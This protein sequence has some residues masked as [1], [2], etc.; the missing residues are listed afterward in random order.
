MFTA[1]GITAAITTLVAVLSMFDS[2]FVSIDRIDSELTA[3]SPDRLQVTLDRFYPTT[4]VG[5]QSTAL[6]GLVSD[7]QPGLRVGSSLRAKAR[8]RRLRG[9]ARHGHAMWTP[10]VIS[11]PPTR[12]PGK[13]SCSPGRRRPTWAS[14]VG[15]TIVLN[16]PVRQGTTFV[17]V[18][19]DVVVSGI[20][21]NPL[22]FLAYMDSGDAGLFGMDGLAN[23]VTV[24]PAAGASQDDVKRALL[25]AAGGGH[26]RDGRRHRTAVPGAAGRDHRNPADRRAASLA[27]ALLIAFNSASIAMEERV[28][29]QA[30]MFAFGLPVRTVMRLLV[31]ES[32][33]TGVLGTIAGVGTGY[34]AARWIIDQFTTSTV[35]ELGMT[36]VLSGGTL[37]VTV[38]LGVLVVAA[39]PLLATRRLAR[40]DIASRLRV[41]E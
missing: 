34:L 28:R 35:P 17:L 16:H 2:V 36:V 30:T 10:R 1:L 40:L 5:Q 21:D 8:D 29:E 19:S 24:R 18:D 31:I 20:H 41:L 13:A 37:A 38:L 15:D 7:W 23:L 9:T 27:L 26:D 6:P 14:R 32:L 33:L 39:A 3:M 4:L 22:R 11:G 12:R 25:R